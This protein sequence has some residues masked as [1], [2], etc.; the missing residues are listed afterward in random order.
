MDEQEELLPLPHFG[1][2]LVGLLSRR[3]VPVSQRQLAITTGLTQGHINK[4]CT[5]KRRLT[6]EV[7]LMIE[8]ATGLSADYLMRLQTGIEQRHLERDQEFQAKLNAI[9]KIA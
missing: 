9:Q 5:G 6:L 1:E 3:I 4:I 8:K 2:L 7:A